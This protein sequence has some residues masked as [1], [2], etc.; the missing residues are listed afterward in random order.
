MMDSFYI[1]ATLGVLAAVGVH[2]ALG[3]RWRLPVRKAKSAPATS[4]PLDVEVVLTRH[5]KLAFYRRGREGAEKLANV[6]EGVPVE[7][8]KWHA[9][10]ISN[11]EEIRASKTCGCFHC[12]AIYE[13]AEITEW[14]WEPDGSSAMCARCQ[15]DSVIG[16]A[17]GAPLNEEFLLEMRSWW[18]W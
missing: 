7:M 12:G 14:M 4:P 2:F 10:A 16:D 13:P 8:R 9:H 3:K 1:P 11:A 5:L 15:V 18:F 6:D 17:S